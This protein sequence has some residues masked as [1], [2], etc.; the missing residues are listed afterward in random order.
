MRWHATYLEVLLLGCVSVRLC[1]HGGSEANLVHFTQS[2]TNN[3]VVYLVTLNQNG[4]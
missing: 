2:L 4:V 1:A 3:H